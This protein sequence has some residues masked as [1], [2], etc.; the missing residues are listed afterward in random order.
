MH[1]ILLHLGPVTIHTY[2][3]LLALAFLAT[4]GVARYAA[5]H[6]LTGFVPLTASEVVDWGCWTMAGG[7]LG[8]RVLYILLNWSTYRTQP[9]EIL[10]IWHGGLVWYGGFAGGIVAQWWYARR[11]HRS[12]LRI[13]DQV[14]PFVTLGHAIGRLGCL[15]N[16]CCYGIPTS[17][18]FGVR[19]PDQPQAVVPTQLFE[20]ASLLVLFLILRS[21][22][23]PPGLKSPGRLFGVY[24]IG[25]G[26]IRWTV[27]YW[28]ANQP[29]LSIGI[30]LHQA[31]SLGLILTGIGLM[32]RKTV[33]HVGDG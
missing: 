32:V 19:F 3:V 13:S 16:G 20:S 12:F 5:T 10:A 23:T 18:W 31:I 4:V 2:G 17:A 27:E 22:Q 14:I 33:T 15:L 9:L 6:S 25:Y 11:A 1:P 8:G 30:T 28:R 24:L 26:I 21:L 29:M 7:I